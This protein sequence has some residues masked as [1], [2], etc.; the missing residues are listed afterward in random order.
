MGK[1]GESVTDSSVLSLAGRGWKKVE[2][3]IDEKVE[4]L[5]LAGNELKSFCG[6]PLSLCSLSLSFNYLSSL[7][8]FPPL[9]RLRELDLSSNNL[10]SL[11]CDGKPVLLAC[12]RLELLSVANNQLHSCAG[13]EP[14][15]HLC[16][17]DVANN[18]VDEWECVRYLSVLPRLRY[19]SLKG[20]PIV[21]S[22]KLKVG[23]R[24]YLPTLCVSSEGVYAAK[25][26]KSTGSNAESGTRRMKE[27]GE[28][29]GKSVSEAMRE[30]KREKR[31]GEMKSRRPLPLASV[32]SRS[33]T[34]RVGKKAEM[35]D[36]AVQAIPQYVD[37]RVCHVNVQADL[38]LS[39]EEESENSNLHAIWQRRYLAVFQELAVT[40]FLLDKLGNEVGMKRGSDEEGSLAGLLAVASMLASGD[41]DEARVEN[42][43]C[44]LESTMKGEA[45]VG[46]PELS[47]VVAALLPYFTPPTH[48]SHLDHPTFEHGQAEP[49]GHT[50]ER[51]DK[52]EER[53]SVHPNERGGRE[54]NRED[55][56]R[57]RNL[58]AQK[59]RKSENGAGE[60]EGEGESHVQA[61][62]GGGKNRK[63]ETTASLDT[64]TSSATLSPPSQHSSFHS[65]PI[66][67]SS[68]PPPHYRPPVD[69]D[70]VKD[71][72]A[73][74]ADVLRT[75]QMALQ[76]I[77][78]FCRWSSV[79]R[80]RGASCRSSIQPACFSFHLFPSACS[81]RWRRAICVQYHLTSTTVSQQ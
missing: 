60:G 33:P 23:M 58:R 12:T 30:K 16:F 34:S 13:V 15:S 57:R 32:V 49:S 68:L 73:L 8:N 36:A 56:R 63:D 19:L 43:R 21:A 78:R 2:V 64:S 71:Y 76:S 80:R 51:Q 66:S 67:P 39:D 24:Q 22:S 28:K 50:S 70:E 52:D 46:K 10:S 55:K 40:R 17:F 35:K 9:S 77:F 26:K 11:L 18:C 29:E 81:L 65:S 79:K 14:L 48:H 20:N 25:K 47:K 72:I 69:A 7:N 42:E 59:S 3:E 54:N 74:L 44:M 5:D 45:E 75:G 61:G 4:R 27:G 38:K 41:A 53:S 6:I 37:G 62:K 31:S 1:K